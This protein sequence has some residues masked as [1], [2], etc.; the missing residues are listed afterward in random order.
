MHRSSAQSGLNRL[1]NP[2]NQPTHPP[3]SQVGTWMDGVTGTVVT[4]PLVNIKSYTGVTD[5]WGSLE[6]PTI[7]AAGSSSRQRSAGVM[8]Q[9]GQHILL[10]LVHCNGPSY[11]HLHVS[12]L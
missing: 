3:P 7:G 10:Q 5:S 11:S 2:L 4:R 1:L 6:P 12:S 8:L 9:A